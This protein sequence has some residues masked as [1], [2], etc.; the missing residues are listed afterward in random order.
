M[1]EITTEPGSLSYNRR[2]S[3]QTE[4]KPMTYTLYFNGLV[5]PTTITGKDLLVVLGKFNK[6][7]R[8]RACVSHVINDSYIGGYGWRNARGDIY[9]IQ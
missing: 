4:T 8:S 1:T 7:C 2:I 6:H 3:K 9:E 5:Q